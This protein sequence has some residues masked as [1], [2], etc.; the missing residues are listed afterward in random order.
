MAE[1]EF[2]TRQE[3]GEFARR[4]DAENERQNKRLSALEETV[5]EI[6]K[7]S[8][9]IE[10]MTTSIQTMTTELTKQ[11]ERIEGIEAKPGKRWEALIGGII[12]A[13]A[14]A[15]GAAVMAGIIH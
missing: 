8:L 14:A 3:H 9:S 6:N 15:I 7:L 10:R 1:M 2:I 5:K 12:G 11:G 13:V 4:I